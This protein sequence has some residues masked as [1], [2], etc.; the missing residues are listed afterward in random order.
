MAKCVLVLFRGTTVRIGNSVLIGLLA[1]VLTLAGCAN[2]PSKEGT[3][4]VVGGVVGGVLGS[5]VG[6]GS[7]R[8]AATVAGT[9]I[10]AMIGSSVGRS[11]DE[12]D[13]RK[14]A[15]A[16]EYNRT[17][18]PS[19]WHNPDSGVDYRV[20]PTRTYETASGGPCREYTTEV[21]VGGKRET[22]YGTACRQPDGSWKIVK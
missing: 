12:L 7:G 10:G 16:L 8:A 18:Q 2:P 4:T 1:G 15:E 22:A 19:A 17:N 5:Q 3:G 6:K 20:T 14:A 11:M 13:R 21:L 9:V